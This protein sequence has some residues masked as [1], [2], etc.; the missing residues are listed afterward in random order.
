MTN[1]LMSLT[2]FTWTISAM[3]DCAS[4]R[5]RQAHAAFCVNQV[6]TCLVWAVWTKSP[7]YSDDRTKL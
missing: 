4:K 3:Q 6:A 7:H 2:S 5:K 1:S